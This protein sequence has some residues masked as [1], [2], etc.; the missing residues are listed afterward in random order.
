MHLIGIYLFTSG[1]L[2]T[3]LVLPHQSEC[4][5]PPASATSSQSSGSTEQGCWHP[6]TFDK[7]VVIIIDALRYDFTVPFIPRDG[8]LTPHAFH[9]SIPFLYETAL[10]EPS[11]AFLR[12]FIADPPTTTLQRLK[13]LTTGTLPT[14]IDA[15]SNFAGTAIDED[16][17]IEKLHAHGKNVVHLGDDTWHA[18]FP[19]YFDMNLTHA[20]D[21]F[22]VWDLHTLDNGVNEHIFPL[23]EPANQNKWDVLIGHYLGVDHAGHRYGPD[24][25][26]MTAK[27]RQTDDIIRRIAK[28]IE[29]DTLLIVMGDHGMDSKGDHG[30]ESDEE[31]EA[32][33][34]MYSRK[35]IFGR[36]SPDLVTPSANAKLRP[37][38]QIDLVPTLA[39]LLGLPIPFNNLGMPIEE[40]FLGVKGNDWENLAKVNRITSAQIHQY[41]QEYALVRKPE[42]GT[43]A[44]PE[45]LWAAASRV[46][47]Q[48]AASGKKLSQAQWQTTADHF[49]AYQEQNLRICKDLWARFDVPSMVEGI[50]ILFVSLLSLLAYACGAHGDL[51][52]ASS[53]ALR[54]GSIGLVAGGLVGAIAGFAIP[55]FGP[56]RTG[57]F[58]GAASSNV[59]LA[60]T[61]NPMSLPGTL[62]RLVPASPWAYLCALPTLLLSI[63]FAANSF[64]VWEDEIL[65]FFLAS[66]AIILLA[67]CFR[68]TTGSDRT[69]AIFH[70][71]VFLISIRI[72]S[73]SRLCRE[74]QAAQCFTTFY[75][76]AASTTSAPWQLAVSWIVALILPNA[77][78]SYYQR[79]DSYH[80][81]GPYWI[82]IAFQISCILISVYWTVEAADDGAWFPSVSTETLK[83]TRMYLA[84]LILAVAA[85]AGTATFGLQPP[86]LAVET[87]PAP[88]T[89]SQPA[90][91]NGA[92]D[93]RP[94]LLVRGTQNLYGAHYATLPLS[95]LSIPLLLVQKPMGQGTLAL[96]ILAI[97]SLLEL[98]SLL[99]AHPSWHAHR[100]ANPNIPPTTILQTAVGPALLALLAHFLFFK[101]GHQ[102]VL[103]SI[104]WDAAFLATRTVRY[105][106]SPLLVALNTFGGQLLGAVAV[107]LC[108]LWRRRYRFSAATSAS[109]TAAADRHAA[110]T[111]LQAAVAHAALAHLAVYAALDL[112]T[113]VEVAWLRRHLMLY[114]V[115]SP[116]WMM[117]V[118]GLGVADV[119]VLVGVGAVGWSVGAVGGVLGW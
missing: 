31:V 110:R 2:L 29:D 106:L 62:S 84:Q 45:K 109:G 6:K 18:L 89:P 101:T 38:N 58:L 25:A 94:Q 63:G 81:S 96:G 82:G 112:A 32:A 48:G 55:S 113:S 88:V 17:L 12:P 95:V 60:L 46:W 23:L 90:T 50:T 39:L 16:N 77:V 73:L 99:S 33:L 70:S 100:R 42:A 24:H 8:D 9:N 51:V 1:F 85:G 30:G 116:R 76:S 56:L 93:A 78:K 91:P 47:D 75:A 117:G 27:L 35:G 34:W 11:N 72:A 92:P 80:A 71:A 13:G 15:G 61:L 20:F 3:R 102:A 114:R 59:G 111:A 107:P 19:G 103:S 4:A 68:L 119:G 98:I 118:A 43:M 14:F 69:M 40:A 74:E 26:A 54:R 28:N 86:H 49:L 41:Q 5:V 22:N 52:E 104:Q 97:L 108:V 67:A 115:F 79:T 44:V 53:N 37:V 36:S 105:P 10:K 87:A 64:T 65:L 7:A 21:S 83:T 66:I 57:L